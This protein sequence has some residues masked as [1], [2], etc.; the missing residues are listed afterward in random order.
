MKYEIPN[1]EYITFSND[2]EFII[3]VKDIENN[4]DLKIMIKIKHFCEQQIEKQYNYKIDIKED[5][6]LIS[7]LILNCFAYII[8]IIYGTYFDISIN[9][10]CFLG[11]FFALYL[12]DQTKRM[13]YE[14][15][16]HFYLNILTGIE[17]KLIEYQ[18]GKN[19]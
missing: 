6:L 4:N 7:G 3:D 5:K 12:N 11:F 19:D 15:R 14:I 1:S 13:K 2:N 9:I 10:L 8:S 18:L 17:I 16:K